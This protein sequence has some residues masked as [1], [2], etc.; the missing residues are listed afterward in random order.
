MEI[1]TLICVNCPM[2]CSIQVE[3]EGN[4][5]H[6]I[7]GNRCPKGEAYA[8]VECIDPMR[9]LTSTV[10]I[11]QAPLRV[12]PVITK[13]EIPLRKVFEAME[14]IRTLHVQAPIACGD[15]LCEDLAHTGV[16]L[17]ASRSMPKIETI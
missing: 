7:Q 1:K 3:L 16:A 8:R 2:G 12:L 4:Q 10:R 5:V 17:V 9:I 11:D 15:V 13:A 14:Q 6:S